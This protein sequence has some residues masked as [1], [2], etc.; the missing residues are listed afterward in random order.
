M[1]CWSRKKYKQGKANK[2]CLK[3]TKRSQNSQ[4][5]ND[6]HVRG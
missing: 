2:I 1:I 3:P 6:L 4:R 5:D